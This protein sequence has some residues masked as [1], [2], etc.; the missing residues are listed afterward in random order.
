M[1]NKFI[2]LTIERLETKQAELS[3]SLARSSRCALPSISRTRSL[4]PIRLHD[5]CLRQPELKTD[6]ACPQGLPRHVA[7]IMGCVGP[8]GQPSGAPRTVRAL[9]RRRETCCARS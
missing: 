3:R 1:T 6:P 7:I 5:A 9:S 4:A 8:L 2:G